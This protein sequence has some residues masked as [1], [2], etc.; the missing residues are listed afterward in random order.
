MKEKLVVYPMLIFLILISACTPPDN[1]D[2]ETKLPVA[3]ALKILR[4]QEEENITDLEKAELY[5]Q[6]LKDYPESEEAFYAIDGFLYYQR[7]ATG[8]LAEAVRDVANLRPLISH[9]GAALKTD[10]LLCSQYSDLNDK[11]GFT[12]LCEKIT[13]QNLAFSDISNLMAISTRF[14]AWETLENLITIAEPVANS[15]AFAAE[16]SDRVLSPEQLERGGNNRKSIVLANKGL[17]QAVSGDLDLAFQTLEEAESLLARNGMDQPI[18]VTFDYFKGKALALKGDFEAAAISLAKSA[19]ANE[20]KA[21]LQELKNI[22]TSI[23]GSD[24]GFADYQLA[25]TRKVT[26]IVPDFDLLGYDG[27]QHSLADLGGKATLIAFWSPT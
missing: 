12:D 7:T 9:A 26:T 4:Q 25:M 8:D 10:L 14:S 20:N 24:S 17:L 1:P 15:E 5:A 2:P 3:E 13:R 27:K 22:Y 18:N 11:A 16:N 23:N 6:F 19:R 21:A